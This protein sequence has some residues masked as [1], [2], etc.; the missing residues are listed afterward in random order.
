MVNSSPASKNEPL[1]PRHRLIA[2][3][4]SRSP[5]TVPEKKQP[6]SPGSPPAAA[7]EPPRRSILNSGARKLASGARRSTKPWP[8]ADRWKASSLALPGNRVGTTSS[9]ACAPVPGPAGAPQTSGG[10]GS[11]NSSSR[12]GGHPVVVGSRSMGA[13]CCGAREREEDRRARA[14]A[15]GPRRPGRSVQEK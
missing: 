9:E 6:R 4:D 3:S 1:S 2:A 13:E 14:G 10:G 12:R 11:C 7:L 8:K 5:F 15:G